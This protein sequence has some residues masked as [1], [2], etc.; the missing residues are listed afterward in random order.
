[1]AR[2]PSAISSR[3]LV[4][5]RLSATSSSLAREA[6]GA[7]LLNY[8]RG[9]NYHATYRDAIDYFYL[10][11]YLRKFQNKDTMIARHTSHVVLPFLD[12][13]WVEAILA[14]PLND[15]LANHIQVDMMRL[16]YPS[17]LRVPRC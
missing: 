2:K 8:L 7:N 13:E 4:P 11:E 9:C 1:M 3:L 15:R 17:L 6:P 16:M 14:V 10:E 5:A 12:Q